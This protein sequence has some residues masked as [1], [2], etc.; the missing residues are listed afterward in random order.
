MEDQQ[1][2]EE[3]VLPQNQLMRLAQ[4]ETR[5]TLP[6]ALDNLWQSLERTAA[7]N[8][9]QAAGDDLEQ[10]TMIEQ[11]AM[12]LTE[13]LNQS[14]G[15]DLAAVLLKGRILDEIERDALFAAHPA[16]YPTLEQ[17]AVDQGIGISELS[18]VRDLTRV[19]FPWLGENLGLD[20]RAVW[21]QV[22]K[23]NMR[24]LTPI[25]KRIITGQ[26][27]R[28]TV[29]ATYQRVIEDIQATAA[30]TNHVLNDEEL[31]RTAITQLLEQGDL[32]TNA[33][34]RQQLRPERA[35]SIDAHIFPG[36][37]GVKYLVASMDV[38]QYTIVSR[39]LHGYWDPITVITEG[40][41]RDQIIAL[42]RQ[43]PVLDAFV[44]SL[45]GDDIA[46][47]AVPV[48]DGELRPEIVFTTGEEG[49][50]LALEEGGALQEHE[51]AAR[52]AAE[53]I[54]VTLEDIEGEIP[55]LNAP[56]AEL[57]GGPF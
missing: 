4:D 51:I 21:E 18:Q 30:E 40:H 29:E 10:Y 7:V 45:L 32:L 52:E 11:R 17:L 9:A 22:G 24:E 8:I 23:S 26:E 44:R 31:Q 16:G 3:N 20:I 43:Y 55:G 37:D 36:P 28:G 13:M 27:A 41:T 48:P 2:P 25:L 53:T 15:L 14:K 34:L 56:D 38:D 54:E 49:E 46:L 35:P 33:N 39:R 6:A 19:I 47:R 5:L 57:D 12:L 1:V 42:L 50:P